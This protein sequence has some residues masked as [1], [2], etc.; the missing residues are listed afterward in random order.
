[1]EDN[2]KQAAD[3]LRN[4]NCSIA[5]TGAGISY[6]S[7]IPTFRGGQNSIWSKY[8]QNDIEIEHFFSNPSKSW[9]TIKAC[10][11]SFMEGKD[12][13]PNKAHL[14]LARL[15]KSGLLKAVI[16]QNIDGLHQ[17]AGSEEVIE[18]HGTTKTLSCVK[19]NNQI[20]SSQ[21]DMA[22]SVPTCGLCGGL[23]KPDFVFFG[24]QLPEKALNDSFYLAENADVC[25]VVG[26]SGVVMPAAMVPVKVKQHGG[27]IIEISPDTT[28]L[29]KY[30]DVHIHLGA[31]EA[32]SQLEKELFS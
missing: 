19:C 9:N 8:D 6:E 28:S 29:T 12:I 26:T 25:I 24:E 2:I 1:M 15:E 27:K 21:F 4:S 11:Y 16:T 32:F 18:L 10:F 17:E 3:I 30:A 23:L 13:K 20:K 5:F 7:G 22:E 31:V 14:V